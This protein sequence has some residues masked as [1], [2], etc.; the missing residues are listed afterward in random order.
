MA[1][2]RIEAFERGSRKSIMLGYENMPWN[3]FL[4]VQCYYILQGHHLHHDGSCS[5]TGLERL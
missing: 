3:T 4:I 2:L 5:S 1:S